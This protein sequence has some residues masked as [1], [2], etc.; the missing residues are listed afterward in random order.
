MIILELKFV[1][2]FYSIYVY[3]SG[4]PLRRLS[5]DQIVLLL[6]KQI[7]HLLEIVD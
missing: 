5:I 6:S 1:S 7:S 4:D 3:K 2:A